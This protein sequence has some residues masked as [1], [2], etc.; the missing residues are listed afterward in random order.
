MKF[1]GIHRHFLRWSTT[2]S[3]ITETKRIGHVGSMKPFLEGEWMDPLKCILA[4]TPPKN[5]HGSPENTPLE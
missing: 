5:E 2:L 3:F 4:Y 1:V